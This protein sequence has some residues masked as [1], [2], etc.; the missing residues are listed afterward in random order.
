M[1]IP[2]SSHFSALALWLALIL[3]PLQSGAEDIDIFVGAGGSPAAPNVIFLVDNSP[4]WSR[5]AQHWP[6]NGGTQ[7]AAELAAI[8][9]ILNSIKPSNPVN[10]GL[11]LLSE[12]AGSTAN[13]ATP[14]TGGGYIR[15]GARDMSV[16]ANRDAL[17]KILAGI[18][19][20]I[21]DPNEK[22]GGMAKKD[23][24]AGFYELYKY[25]S[26]LTPY[27]G[28]LANN[29]NA[30]VSSNTRPFTA[31]GQGLTSDFALVNGRYQSPITTATSCAKTYIIYIANNANNTGY[32]GQRTYEPNILSVGSALASPT[33]LDTWLDEWTRHLS[34]SGVIVPAGN[35]NGQVVTYILDAYKDQ[36]N[37]GY[38]QSL[39]EAARQ[40]GSVSNYYQVGSM[41][42]IE[43]ALNAILAEIQ[44]VNSTF[45]S[46]SLPVNTTNRSQNKNQVFIPMFR[47][48]SKAKP[49][50]MGNLKQYQFVSYS[51]DVILGDIDGNPAV[52]AITGYPN[53]CATSYWTSD[54]P[55]PNPATANGKPEV[56]YWSIVPQIPAAQG[57][58]PAGSPTSP[59][60]RATSTSF[61]P[62]SDAPDGPFVEKGGVAE[63]IRKGNNPSSTNATPTWAVNRN[64]LTYTGGGLS[65]FTSASSGLPATTVDFILGKDVNDENS[66]GNLTETRPSLHGDAVHSRPTPVDYGATT[67]VT[68]YYGANDGS[69]RAV[70]TTDGRERWALIA[71]EFYSTLSRLQTN[72]PAISYATMP[73]GVLPTPT[74]K[75]Y[76]FDGSIGLYQDLSNSKIWI[77][78][79]M[80]RGGRMIYALD[81]TTP[82]TPVF[83]WKTGCPNL[84]NDSGCTSGF[85][86]IGQT[87]SI[88]QAVASIQGYPDPVIIVGGGYDNCEDANTTAPACGS[89]KG[90]GVYVLDANTG[91]LLKYF[92]TTRSVAADVAVVG[93]AN[94]GIIDRAYVVD[95]GGNIYRMD[96]GAS[97]SNWNMNRVAYTNGFG[98]KF[99][100]PP[101]LLPAPGNK[102]Y[103]AIGSGDREHPLLADY[104]YASVTNRFYV[105]LDDLTSTASSPAINLDDAALMSNF[106]TLTSCA[107]ASVFPTSSLKGWFMDLNQNGPGEQTVT[108]ALIVGGMAVFSTNRPIPAAPGSCA[109]TLGE[110][111]GYWVNLFNGSGGIGVAGA[112]GGARS[113]VFIGGGLPPSPVL[114]SVV[115]N[116]KP[117]SVIIGATQKD[118]TT[119]TTTGGEEVKP[120][121]SMKRKTIYWKSSGEN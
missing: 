60:Q 78:P 40:G 73:P 120:A 13:G 16:T 8:S 54:S 86:G 100:Y 70:D 59:A 50:W 48:D 96:F 69:L 68:V 52:S 119:S 88:P 106:T 19:A 61:D 27:T 121:I 84:A 118:G 51:G 77:Y 76:Y 109:N 6:D 110:A 113:S 15:F 20:N 98:R 115:I 39:I 80:R 10:I 64:V 85:N 71:P 94:A 99:F 33:G 102:V 92:A 105:Y 93:T 5:Q 111:R 79:T 14:G 97:T 7:G 11:A 41:V 46:A 26:G 103:L 65:A 58:C 17:Q 53:Y 36:Q 30:D 74:P 43:A 2:H 12:Y 38:S 29:V 112:C 23:E 108:S 90:A 87:W 21:T 82:N 22:V 55:Y 47:P 28:D 114:G 44:G 31:A 72:S 67:G 116:G 63:V 45:A 62:F 9:N 89:A 75:N 81:V 49:L 104:P 35:T 42:Q 34:F 117:V 107:T 3:A 56:P 24:A 91:A 18:Q 95:L 101:A 66:N 37:V 4:N 25:L 1:N 57:L 32:I 83:K